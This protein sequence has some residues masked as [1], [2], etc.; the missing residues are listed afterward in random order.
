MPFVLVTSANDT[1]T[2]DRANGLGADGYLVK[3]FD[4]AAVSECI[5]PLLAAASESSGEGAAPGS[6]DAVADTL[7]DAV[8]DAVAD[9]ETPLATMGRLGI[10]G[11]RLL[12]YLGGFQT[13]LAAASTDLAALLASGDTEAAHVRLDR[14]HASAARPWA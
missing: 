10:D 1:A 13:Q 12:V 14:L 3:P 2:V 6:P 4:A 5:A 7:T 8:P 11:E 9:A